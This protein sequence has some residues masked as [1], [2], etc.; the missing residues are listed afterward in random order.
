MKPQPRIDQDSPWKE[1]LDR[2]LAPFLVF[3]F[4]EVHAAINWARGYEGLDK[5]LQRIIHDA[6]AGRRLADKLFK[7]WLHDGKEAW[8][9]IHIEVQGQREKRFSERMFKY[10]CRIGEYYQHQVVSLAVLCDDNPHWKPE[11]YSYN[12]L[13]CKVDYQFPFAKVLDFIGQEERLEGD[14]NPFAAIVLAQ[15]KTLATRH[16]M[17]ERKT[18]KLRL[19]KGL[20]KRGLTGQEIWQLFRLIDWIMT[21]PE[22]PQREFRQEIFEF[23]E[24]QKMPYVTSIEKMARKEGLRD[25][26]LQSIELDLEIKFEEKDKQLLEEI[27]AISRIGQLRKLARAVKKAKTLDE[28]RKVAK[29]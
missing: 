18:W 14:S 24:E 5:E 27:R 23:E 8:L 17:T 19:I 4:P 26:W 25:G 11:P 28:I 12:M 7:V 9:L 16:S 22:V 6:K 15:L 3:F 20:Y 29:R 13:G 1:A 2:F 10:W 21:L